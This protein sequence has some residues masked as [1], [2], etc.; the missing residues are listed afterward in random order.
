MGDLIGTASPLR[1]HRFRV[2][3]RGGWDDPVSLVV[4]QALPLPLTLA[5]AVPHYQVSEA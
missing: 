1:T 5:A 2:R 4:Q 3:W